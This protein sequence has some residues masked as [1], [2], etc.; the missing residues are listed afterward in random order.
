MA[1]ALGEAAANIY[2]NWD[3]NMKISWEYDKDGTSAAQIGLF[4]F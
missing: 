2:H 4:F 3:L 1:R